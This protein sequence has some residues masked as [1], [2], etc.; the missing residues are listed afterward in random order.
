MQA[1]RVYV[2]V[3]LVNTLGNLLCTLPA[4]AFCPHL[5]VLTE[6]HLHGSK[7]IIE[8]VTMSVDAKSGQCNG[9]P[10]I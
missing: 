7:A 4:E 2:F 8:L 6:R 10:T 5:G 9:K 3:F 1:L